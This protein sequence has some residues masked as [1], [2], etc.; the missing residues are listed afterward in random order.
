MTRQRRAKTSEGPNYKSQNPKTHLP[1]LAKCPDW[2]TIFDEKTPALGLQWLS[3]SAEQLPLESFLFLS[4][5][6]MYLGSI[7]S[8]IHRS[9]SSDR[10]SFIGERQSWI[11]GLEG[12][13]IQDFDS[14]A[15]ESARIADS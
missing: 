12:D 8:I 3:S 4:V 5:G 6:T 10:A 1:T 9:Q 2:N 15:I 7:Q 13:R 11:K 14:G